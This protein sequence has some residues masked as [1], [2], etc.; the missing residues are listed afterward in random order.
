MRYLTF[1]VNTTF[2]LLKQNWTIRHF[3][4]GHIESKFANNPKV[5]FAKLDS[6]KPVIDARSVHPPAGPCAIA[7]ISAEAKRWSALLHALHLG[8]I[9]PLDL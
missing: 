3:I 2:G 4:E 1:K 6:W 7:V 9:G 8:P 5:L